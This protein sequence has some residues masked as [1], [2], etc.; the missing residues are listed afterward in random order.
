MRTRTRLGPG[1]W[2]SS[3][4]RCRLPPGPWSKLPVG[5][6]RV[7]RLPRPAGDCGK[8]PTWCSASAAGRWPTGCSVDQPWPPHRP[9]PA[10]QLPRNLV[11]ERRPRRRVRVFG[12]CLPIPL[13]LG[14]LS[15]G[16]LALLVRRQGGNRPGHRDLLNPT[17]SVKSGS[18]RVCCCRRSIGTSSGPVRTADR[19]ARGHW[20]FT[21]TPGPSSSGLVPALVG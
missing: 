10:G 4:W 6:K 16:G 2:C 15:M 1:S 13:G 18:S 11:V 7:A 12:C 9:I 14:L 3:P 17:C 5:P 20:R 19:P 21:P 8:A